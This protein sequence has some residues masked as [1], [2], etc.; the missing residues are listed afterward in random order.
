[1]NTSSHSSPDNV[2]SFPSSSSR[3][4][5]ELVPFG[6]RSLEVVRAQ[7]HGFLLLKPLFEKFGMNWESQ[8][9]RL[10]RQAWATTCILQAVGADGKVRD[11]VALPINRAAML[12]ATLD[13]SQI[14][15]QKVRADLEQL[16]CEGAEA[17]D[18][19]WRGTPS[20][21][22]HNQPALVPNHI[23]QVTVTGIR[24]ALEGILE[25]DTKLRL[26]EGTIAALQQESQIAG[27][28]VNILKDDT[29]RL[30][31]RTQEIA[32]TLEQKA[33]AITKKLE[34][35]QEFAELTE[36]RVT[37]KL[38]AFPVSGVVELPL[39]EFD[40]KVLRLFAAMGERATQAAIAKRLNAE[41]STVQRAA[42]RLKA[43]KR[44]E[45][46]GNGTGRRYEVTGQI[47]AFDAQ[48]VEAMMA[49]CDCLLDPDTRLLAVR[50][51][52]FGPHLDYR[53]M[54]HVTQMRD[55]R[56]ISSSLRALESNGALNKA[57]GFYR[58]VDYY[59]RA[60]AL[61]GHAPGCQYSS[62]PAPP[63]APPVPQ[64][65]PAPLP[66]VADSVQTSLPDI[67]EPDSFKGLFSER[68]ELVQ[69]MSMYGKLHDYQAE[70]YHRAY[71]QIFA[72]CEAIGIQ[73][74]GKRDPKTGKKIK[75]IV[76]LESKGKC[77][78]A[79]DFARQI[80][81][82]RQPVARPSDMMQVGHA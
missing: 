73:C 2:L 13:A 50:I 23:T 52:E 44:I 29:A 37:E 41:K 32:E 19:W 68:E 31:S 79:L 14:S 69:H 46:F 9:Q 27:Q 26:H 42:D 76:V 66:C 75:P 36:Q 62:P 57:D 72:N 58:R 61:E 30:H 24:A 39:S 22:V 15:D 11:M 17:L 49:A 47:P 60:S 6:G 54:V 77:G 74:R 64:S 18:R 65:A 45:S 3:P 20:E 81:P 70:D 38:Q 5:I 4:S 28:A 56:R 8:R 7:A 34:A 35:V 43:L 78:I 48:A 10:Q 21:A 82:I 53:M 16:Q 40:A 71:N 25:I 33:Q 12:F 63:P 59:L 55:Y 1:V 80:F 67:V 51:A